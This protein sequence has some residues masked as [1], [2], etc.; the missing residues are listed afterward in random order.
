MHYKTPFSHNGYMKSLEIYEFM[1][2]LEENKLFDKIILTQN[3]C[4]LPKVAELTIWY[5][6]QLRNNTVL[7]R[8]LWCRRCRI[9]HYV[10]SP[11]LLLGH[12][13]NYINTIKFCLYITHH[14]AKFNVD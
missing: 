3:Q 14:L 6:Q 1:F 5:K 9:H 7:S 10:A 8:A 12:D 2:C 11:L 13:N 4:I